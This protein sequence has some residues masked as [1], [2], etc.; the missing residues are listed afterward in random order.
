MSGT[1]YPATQC[2]IPEEWNHK[3]MRRENVKTQD[4]K[5]GKNIFSDY[6]VRLIT[7]AL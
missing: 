5:S 3:Q 2:H 4:V 7:C 6:R 1:D